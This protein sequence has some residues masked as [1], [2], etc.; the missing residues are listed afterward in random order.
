MAY[1][2]LTGRFTPDPAP[3]MTPFGQAGSASAPTSGIIPGFRPS[4]PMP[5]PTRQPGQTGFV[6]PVAPAV[7]NTASAVA[8]AEAAA[9]AAEERL[10]TAKTS[11][12][13]TAANNALAAAERVLAE[14]KSSKE[15]TA[16]QEAKRIADEKRR[17]GQ[18]AY[19]ILFSEFDRYGL[20][21]LV[22]EVQQYIV[23]GF[24]EAE[25]TM[26]LRESKPYQERFAANAKRIAA[27]F[28]AIDEAT[29]L[30]LEDSYQSIMQNYGLSPS[31]YSKGNL[32]VQ[33]GFEKLI[34]GNVDPVTLEER[35]VEGQK[36]TKG[37]KSIIDT[38]KQFFP[39]LTDGDFLAYV[40]DPENALSEIKRKVTAVEIGAGAVN[41]DLNI[42]LERALELG[43]AGITKEQAERGFTTIGAG[44]QRGS[45]LASIYQQDPYT[46]AVAESEV[47][48]IPGAQQARKQREKITGLER[49]AFSG[50]T[51]L[52]AGALTRD[53]AGGY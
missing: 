53:R 3:V 28:R 33:K 48:N 4:T 43:T 49:A 9:T 32:G 50:Q 24:S 1:D 5:T 46:Q 42:N 39:T 8:Q 18:S 6:G 22:Q 12:E 11:A 31:Y 25:F 51:G 14:I 10:T 29:Y 27:G 44:L 47:F 40:L 2:P 52:T 21:S 17:S 23:D 13:L 45:Q 20:G 19:N 35:I 36:V 37:S 7:T 41:A 16:Q 26:K 38:A 30:A 34:A 15:L